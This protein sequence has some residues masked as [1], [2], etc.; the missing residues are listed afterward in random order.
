M[1]RNRAF[2]KWAGGKYS[3][4][5]KIIPSL[6][7]AELLIEPFFGAGS[8]S[9][10]AEFNQ[11]QLNDINTDLVSLYNI[12]QQQPIAFTEALAPMF[13]AST[14]L[15]EFYYQK[16]AEFNNTTDPFRRAVLFV[17]LN[18]HGYNGLCRYNSKGGFNVPFGRYVKPKLPSQE[19]LQ[20]AKRFK[21]ASFTNLNYKESMLQAPEETVIYCDP[22]YIPISKTASFTQYA[23][24]GFT[25]EDQRELGDL[26][27]KLVK[28]KKLTI[29]I[30][31]HDT[32][33]TR[34]FYKDAKIKSFSA[35][36]FI[37]QNASTRKPVKELL[38][39]FDS[40]N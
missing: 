25:I 18:R 30:S 33:L 20:F 22:P 21:N 4:L 32:A 26:A 31:N 39:I 38:A 12:V 7:K 24:N 23:A 13:V 17:Y 35:K 6:P 3:L 2:L 36:R 19:I 10:N 9:L 14:N 28:E 34:E 16:R 40:N 5:D 1:K 8:V 37:S 15:S 29:V 11:Y 27:S